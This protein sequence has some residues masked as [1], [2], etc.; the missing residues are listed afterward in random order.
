MFAREIDFGIGPGKE[1]VGQIGLS[2]NYME[3]TPTAH[4]NKITSNPYDD[5]TSM[6]T[7]VGLEK[8]IRELS[9]Y[10]RYYILSLRT[11]Q[12]IPARC[13]STLCLSFCPL[14]LFTSHEVDMATFPSLTEK[15]LCEIGISAWGARR[16]I[17]LLIAGT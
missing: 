11:P 10:F 1:R 17:M 15:D 2:S 16:K 12:R 3:H 4:L 14:G 5:L 13:A 7:S 8:Y 6:L 9:P